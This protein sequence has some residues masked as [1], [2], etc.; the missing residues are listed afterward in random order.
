[1]TARDLTEALA[2]AARDGSKGDMLRLVRQ[3]L[4]TAERVADV[5]SLIASDP[6]TTNDRR[7]DALIA[8]AVEDLA[9]RHGVNVPGWT[10]AARRYLDEPWYVMDF[11]SPNRAVQAETPPALADHGVYIRFSALAN[12]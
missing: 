10:M 3:F 1:M 4:H 7:W 8:G 2:R 12:V 11:A 5:A 6:G 9:I